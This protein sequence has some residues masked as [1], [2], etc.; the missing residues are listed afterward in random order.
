MAAREQTVAAEGDATARDI[1]ALRNRLTASES[2]ETQAVAMLLSSREELRVAE[3]KIQRAMS[4]GNR[5]A[6]RDGEFQTKVATLL[7]ELNS[8]QWISRHDLLVDAEVWGV[9]QAP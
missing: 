7:G 3:D 9:Q 8:T 5:L 1:A 6:A 2:D 4:I